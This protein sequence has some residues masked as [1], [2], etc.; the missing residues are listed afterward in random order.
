MAVTWSLR[1][2]LPSTTATTTRRLHGCDMEF[3]IHV[4]VHNGKYS[5]RLHGCDMEFGIHVAVHN[6]N[7]N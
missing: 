4:V 1:Y 6:G 5:R 3:E 7:Y 2:T